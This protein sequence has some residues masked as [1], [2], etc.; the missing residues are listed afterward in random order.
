[1]WTKLMRNIDLEEPTQMGCTQR[2]SGT[3]KMIVTEKSDLFSEPGIAQV[4][5][6]QQSSTMPPSTT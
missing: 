3:N 6:R 4:Q 2:E 1:M 5:T